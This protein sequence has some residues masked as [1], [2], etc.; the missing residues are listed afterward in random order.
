MD[1]FFVTSEQ[2]TVTTVG[3][4]R[5]ALR[6]LPG[7]LPIFSGGSN[8]TPY[9]GILMETALWR[10]TDRKSRSVV[11]FENTGTSEG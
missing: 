6:A 10:N 8:D 2:V 5:E 7:D 9:I 1:T 11:L 3:E 4:L